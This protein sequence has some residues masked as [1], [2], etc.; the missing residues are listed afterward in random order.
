LLSCQFEKLLISLSFSNY[1]IDWRMFSYFKPD[2]YKIILHET[3][4]SSTSK[5]T[6]KSTRPKSAPQKTRRTRKSTTKK[7]RRRHS[8]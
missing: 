6:R 5:N 7:T 8:R 2:W 1:M 3:K 4:S